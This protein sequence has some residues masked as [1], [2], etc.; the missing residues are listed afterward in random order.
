MGPYTPPHNGPILAERVIHLLKKWGIDKKKFSLTL[1]NAKYNDGLVNVL[2]HHLSLTN[3]L[4]CD[5][6]FFHIRC[7]AHILNLIVQEGLK[8]TDEAIHNVRESVKYVRGSEARKIKFA[9]CMNQ[10][11]LSSC[12]SIRQDVPTRWNSTYLMLECALIHRYA[13]SQLQL[14]DPN[15]KT[16]PSNEEWE[17]VER[18]TKVF[19]VIL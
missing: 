5:G 13:F 3:T 19:E 4:L 2:K 14:I 10:L 15:F 9:E 18:I 1:D 7:S 8:V 11:S 12:R 16:C 17:R 6:N